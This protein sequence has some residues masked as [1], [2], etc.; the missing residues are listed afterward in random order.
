MEEEAGDVEEDLKELW[1]FLKF[2]TIF[3]IDL[4]IGVAS[5]NKR[6][7][8]EAVTIFSEQLPFYNWTSNTT[9]S[10]ILNQTDQL[11][12]GDYDKKLFFDYLGERYHNY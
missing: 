6:L 9:H 11:V 8:S 12:N 2:S 5:K 3:A 10:Y 1:K 7:L 4:S